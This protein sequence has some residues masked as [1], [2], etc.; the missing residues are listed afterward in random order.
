VS[1]AGDVTVFRR[2]LKE[3]SARF[4]VDVLGPVD[5]PGAAPQG[6]LLQL[7]GLDRPVT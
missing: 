6:L 4:V 1:F 7:L 5:A 2:R 3:Q